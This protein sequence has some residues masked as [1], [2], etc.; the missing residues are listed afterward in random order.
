L[1]STAN[2]SLSDV[3]ET[4]VDNRL[5]IIDGNS[6]YE[7]LKK[8][9]NISI[10]DDILAIKSDINSYLQLDNLDKPLVSNSAQIKIYNPTTREELNISLC[11]NEQ[12]NIRTPIKTADLLN[13]TGYNGLKSSGIDGFNPN[14]TSFTDICFTHVD[15]KTQYDTTLTYRRSNYFQNKSAQCSGTNCTYENIDD[16][17]Y[18][19]C[20]C[21]V[22]PAE[23][24]NNEFVDYFLVNLSTWN[25]GVVKC[26][27]LIFKVYVF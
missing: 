3:I 12:F 22:Q 20:N 27:N 25:F 24:I 18:V 16:N 13:L 10:T 9:Y 5:S 26:Y 19:S 7:T 21:Y 6:C 1:S 14:D 2:E 15:V 8:Y 23:Q 4:A 17:N 11:S